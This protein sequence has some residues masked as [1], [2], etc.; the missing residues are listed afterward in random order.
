M[1][2]RHPVFCTF[3]QVAVYG[4]IWYGG[5]VLGPYFG[6]HPRVNTPGAGP[7]Y[8]WNPTPVPQSPPAISE[9]LGA[10]GMPPHTHTH[11]SGRG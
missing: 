4:E 8:R 3:G 6:R 7:W 5:G 9:G 11:T 1:D 10:L 2:V